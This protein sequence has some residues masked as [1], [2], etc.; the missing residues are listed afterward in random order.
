MLANKNSTNPN[1]MPDDMALALAMSRSESVGTDDLKQVYATS[2]QT[3]AHELAEK[4]ELEMVLE[5]SK[6]SMSSATPKAHV[7]MQESKSPT[8]PL[9]KAIYVT[10]TLHVIHGIQWSIISGYPDGSSVVNASFVWAAGRDA[11]K[12]IAA[13]NIVGEAPYCFLIALFH[14]NTEFFT[15]RGIMS[16]YALSEHL[17]R[18]GLPPRP[19]VMYEQDTIIPVARLFRTSIHVNIVDAPDHSYEVNN[20]ITNESILVVPLS[21]NDS[22]YISGAE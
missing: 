20:E 15:G 1:L 6:T 21:L 10:K 4:L 11:A 2:M 22:H 3:A 13:G 9:P 7:C 17:K 8:T 16:P 18:V 5:M 12:D 14:G 19:G